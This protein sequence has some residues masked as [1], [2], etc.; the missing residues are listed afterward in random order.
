MQQTEEIFRFMQ[1]YSFATIVSTGKN[2]I[3]A[4]HVPVEIEQS[5][6]G[7]PLIRTHIA[8]AN[9]QWKE[10]DADIDVLVIFNGPHT[11]ISSSWYDHVNVPTWNYQAVHVYGKPHILDAAEAEA[12]LNRLVS[13]YEQQEGKRF[14]MDQMERKDID[15]HIK[16]LVAFEISIDRIDAKAKLSQNRNRENFDRILTALDARNDADSKAIQAAMRTIRDTIR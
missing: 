7:N 16:A 11:Y 6:A 13:R 8:R 1:T 5:A 10:F 2:G 4:T 3:V 12:M 15:D 9:P 14:S